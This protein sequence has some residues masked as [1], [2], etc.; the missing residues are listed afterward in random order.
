MEIQITEYI[1]VAKRAEELG[2][3]VPTDLAILPINFATATTSHD[4]IHESTAPTIRSLWRQ[5]GVTE[6]RLEK[7]GDKLPQGA[8]KS[9]EWI[10]P[11][12]Y[13]SEAALTGVAVPLTINM[14]SNYLYD[15]FKGR[16]NKAKI[17]IRFAVEPNKQTED[18]DDKKSLLLTFDGTSKDWQEFDVDKLMQ[19]LEKTR[20]GN[21]I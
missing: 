20:M 12:I 9:A 10:S 18:G 3:N 2:L 17:S 16:H 13:I 8:K 1:D 4:L 19:L 14:I 5:A 21:K 6:T 7:E 11:I 15:L